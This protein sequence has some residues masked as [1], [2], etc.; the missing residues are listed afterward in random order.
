MAIYNFVKPIFEY[1]CVN[2][3]IDQDFVREIL[4][5]AL[6]EASYITK[7]VSGDKKK[8]HL[9]HESIFRT[10]YAILVVRAEGERVE[11]LRDVFSIIEAFSKV[12]AGSTIRMSGDNTRTY[13]GGSRDYDVL[14][15]VIDSVID[16]LK[17][18]PCFDFEEKEPIEQS[19]SEII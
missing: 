16:F 15:W 13:S 2:R 12:L 9:N 4:M 7:Q 3:K 14:S 10:A 19:E 18:N 8:Y 1:L 17:D 5:E 11:R 6:V